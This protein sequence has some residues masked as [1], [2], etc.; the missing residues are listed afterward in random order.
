MP[1]IQLQW[2][3]MET[4]VPCDSYLKVDEDELQDLVTGELDVDELTDAV[5]S[6]GYYDGYYFDW[7]PMSLDF[8]PEEGDDVWG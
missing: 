5:I 1:Y 3:Q 2:V 7:A 6:S 8:E 4:T